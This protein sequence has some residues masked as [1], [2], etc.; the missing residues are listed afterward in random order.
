MPG[1]SKDLRYERR[2][3]GHLKTCAT[4]KNAGFKIESDLETRFQFLPAKIDNASKVIGRVIA[5]ALACSVVGHTIGSAHQEARVT[6][7]EHVAPIIFSACVQCHRPAGAAPFSLLTY[8][9][10]RS[11]ATLVAEVTRRRLMP[12]WKPEAGHGEFL[13][14]RRLSDAQISV[15]EAWAARGAIEGDPALLPPRPTWRSDWQLGEPD[16]VLEP[17]PYT[18]PAGDADVYR[19]F[20]VPIS[21]TKTLFIK[22]WQFVPG[23]SP[24]LHHATIQFDRSG[25]ARRLDTLDPRPGYE[26]LIPH[27]VQSPDG[28]FL[29]WTPGQMTQTA[30]DGMAWAVQPGTDLVMMLHLRPSGRQEQIR[31]KIGLYVSDEP[32][33]RT[34]TMIRLTRQDLDIPP[35]EQ[36]YRVSDSFRLDVDVDLHALQP[37]AH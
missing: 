9:D 10:V 11:R 28:F 29:G 16:L 7:T 6:F 25:D 35:G 3:A 8:D 32:P 13:G 2:R 15:L 24:S 33:S 31:P 34:P 1:R 36:A 5:T 26:G 12:P 30:A 17:P 37:H 18:L 20:V 4:S 21:T 27:T 23:G 22:A 14:E 19:N